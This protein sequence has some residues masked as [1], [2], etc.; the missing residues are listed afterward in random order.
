MGVV[1][2]TVQA[3]TGTRLM[4]YSTAQSPICRFGQY[5]W[6]SFSYIGNRCSYLSR[7]LAKLWGNLLVLSCFLLS[8]W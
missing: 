5:N 3:G 7:W 2:S 4:C 1:I 6:L 8:F